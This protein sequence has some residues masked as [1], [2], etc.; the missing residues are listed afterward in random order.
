MCAAPPA[1]EPG[2]ISAGF[3]EVTLPAKTPALL[4]VEGRD[5]RDVWLLTADDSAG[6]Q[7]LLHWD[8]GAMKE[9]RVSCSTGEEQSLVLGGEELIVL[10]NY[11]NGMTSVDQEARRS[12]KGAW[13]CADREDDTYHLP[14][15]AE[16]LHVVGWR[17]SVPS[18]HTLARPEFGDGESTIR[19][20][21]IAGRAVDDVWLASGKD[22]IVLHWN[23]V[24]WED[25]ATGLPSVQSIHVSASGAVWVAAG[26]SKEQR[27]AKRAPKGK[28]D[29]APREGNVVLRWDP[30]AR[31]WAC[32]PTP[33]GL[34]TV[35]VLGASDH[36]VWLIGEEQEIYHWDGQSFQRAISPIPH[37]MDAWLSPAGELWLAG[38][39]D[40]KNP[41]TETG[42]AYRTRAGGNP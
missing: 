29:K 36:D 8:G 35:Q 17:G 40:P 15:V 13:S 41:G 18:S 31:A 24:V 25:R 42:L 11:D 3:L 26:K 9:E 4:D 27:P 37:L 6:H 14:L 1:G 30:A 2:P 19:A 39:S 32:L 21:K 34:Y 20:M 28:D 22:P 12:A 23:G 16:A 5:D 33:E 38:G 10:G 7:A